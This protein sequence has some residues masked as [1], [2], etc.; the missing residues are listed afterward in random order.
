MILQNDAISLL[1]EL[2]KSPSITPIEAGVLTILE[3]FLKSLGFEIFRLKFSGD[4]SYEVDNLFAIYRGKNHDK[5]SK[6]L[7]FAGHTDVVPVGDETHWKYP[8]FSAHIENGELWGRGA[9]D[10]KS[11][12]AAFCIAAKMAIKNGSLD[13]GIISLA[14]TNDEE[15]DAINGTEK[16]M[17]WAKKN[18]YKFDFAIVGEPSSKEKV[19]DRIK[20]GR[21][22][23]FDG[24]IIVKGKQ[25]H[26]AYPE[27]YKNP[28]PIIAKI[29][30]ALSEQ[31]LD[32]GTEKFQPSSLQISTIDVGNK[33][34]NIIPAEAKLRFNIRYNN[35]WNRETL[36]TEI[37][38]RIDSVNNEGTKVIFTNPSRGADCF[39]FETGKNVALLDEI[40][41]K[42]RG[43]K[44]DH[45]T[46][47]GTSDARFIAKYCPVVECGLVGNHMHAVDERVPLNQLGELINIY[48]EFIAS[49]FRQKN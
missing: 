13:N 1:S 26:I 21:R 32:G 41:A 23:S 22:G 29:A 20:I 30:L 6:H 35:L 11:G 24:M 36:F 4:G 25:G 27:K 39:I 14:I 3:K 12:I 37:K 44:P 40:I 42:Q 19:G 7:L 45:S 47:G 28:I 31:P 2:I 33:A 8:P 15:A 34:T 43:Y 16:I 18:G 5:N 9:T 46:M 38:R 10:M 17:S 48:S 49:F